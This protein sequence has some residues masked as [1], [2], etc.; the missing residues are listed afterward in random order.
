MAL[1]LG[2]ASSPVTQ[3]PRFTRND[4]LPLCLEVPR[5]DRAVKE[6]VRAIDG[7]TVFVYLHKTG[8]WYP[9]MIGIGGNVIQAGSAACT[10]AGLGGQ[11]TETLLVFAPMALERGGS[12]F[13]WV[14]SCT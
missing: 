14:C 6:R 1:N 11:F 5:P 10:G 9:S 3:I 13:R 2:G 12:C 4:L 7:R 8:A